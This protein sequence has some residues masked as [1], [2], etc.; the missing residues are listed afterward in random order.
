[1]KNVFLYVHFSDHFTFCLRCKQTC[2]VDVGNLNGDLVA[3]LIPLVYHYLQIAYYKGS[4][5]NYMI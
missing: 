5:C 2:Q 1:V 3:D 4:E